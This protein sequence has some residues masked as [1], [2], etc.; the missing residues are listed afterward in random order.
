M[1]RDKGDLSI[2]FYFVWVLNDGAWGVPKV[3]RRRLSNVA[4]DAVELYYL[5]AIM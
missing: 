3:R 4:V 5:I 2:R 1:R